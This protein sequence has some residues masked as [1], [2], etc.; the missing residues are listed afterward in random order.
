MQGCL[1]TGHLDPTPIIQDLLVSESA[2]ILIF[3]KCVVSVGFSKG[4]WSLRKI[5]DNLTVDAVTLSDA[6]AARGCWTPALD[7][8]ISLGLLEKI[9]EIWSQKSTKKTSGEYYD[10]GWNCR[11]LPARIMLEFLKIWA[12][13]IDSISEI[14][15]L[16]RGRNSFFDDNGCLIDS[17]SGA[18]LHR[19]AIRPV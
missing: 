16:K 2:F 14:K 18:T 8:P 6:P 7:N 15:L 3:P 12:G 4:D 17:E 9:T 10:D 13:K 1:L 19:A 5:E 11:T